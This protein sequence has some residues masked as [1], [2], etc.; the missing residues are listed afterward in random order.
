[1]AIRMSA[2][3]WT[4]NIVYSIKGEQ[5]REFHKLMERVEPNL[6]KRTQSRMT[7]PQAEALAELMRKWDFPVE[8]NETSDLS[9]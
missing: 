3:Y 8:V 5:R 1:M 4:V 7:K 2:S 9:F 6:Y